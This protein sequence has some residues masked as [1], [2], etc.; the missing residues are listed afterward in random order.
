MSAT[1]I[2]SSSA[3]PPIPRLVR[4]ESRKMIDTRAGLW[5][6]LITALIAVGGALGQSLGSSGSLS[7]AGP[8]FLTAVAGAS[9]LLPIVAILL[10]TSEW[11]QRSGLITFALVPDRPRIVL[12]KFA[13]AMLLALGAAAICLLLGLL[14]G[15]LFGDGASI[16]GSELGQGVLFLTISVG[17]GVGL[18]LLFMNSPLA[19]V[20]IFAGP[21][22]FGALGA[23]SSSINDVT[24]W[25][26]QSELSSLIDT[27]GFTDIDWPK[28]WVT[29]LFWV[30]LTMALGL[31]RLRQTDID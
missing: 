31:L 3:R 11:S 29:V 1:A 16:S 10:V 22:L 9:V 6:L 25:L 26:D 2:T 4:V 18:G 5:L 21:I 23:I 28:I 12:A 7:E 20:L 15:T 13:A 19:I 14:G 27:D 24:T 17:I 8:T 30:V